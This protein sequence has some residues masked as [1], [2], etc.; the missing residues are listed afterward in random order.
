MQQPELFT[1]A[2]ILWGC[3]LI[4]LFYLMMKMMKV[5]NAVRRLVNTQE[6]E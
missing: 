4:F 6:Q 1:V 3:I 2:L 5:E